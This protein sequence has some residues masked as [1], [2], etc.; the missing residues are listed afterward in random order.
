MP[1][2]ALQPGRYVPEEAR[3]DRK[4][5]ACIQSEEAV[6]QVGGG[7]QGQLGE[8]TAWPFAEACFGCGAGVQWLTLPLL[9]MPPLL[10]T[11]AGTHVWRRRHGTGGTQ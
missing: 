4:S 7:R 10:R 1:C 8:C 2:P 3:A 5:L 9:P 6:L 11:G